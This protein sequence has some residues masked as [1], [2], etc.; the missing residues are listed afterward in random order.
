MGIGNVTSDSLVVHGETGTF[1]GC[2]RSGNYFFLF[3]ICK[4][5]LRRGD[6]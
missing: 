3:R 6:S 4:G 2:F 5:N 1:G